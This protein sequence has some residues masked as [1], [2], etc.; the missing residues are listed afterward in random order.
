MLEEHNSARSGDESGM[1]YEDHFYEESKLSGA[2]S[3]E[4]KA[5]SVYN[6]L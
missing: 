2:E 1:D 4:P 5:S 3:A 6:L